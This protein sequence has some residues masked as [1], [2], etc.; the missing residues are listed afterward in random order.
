MPVAPAPMHRLVALQRAD[1]S[2]DL[3]DAFAAAI[4]V[5]LLKLEEGLAGTIGS[6][7]EVRRAWATAIALVWLGQHAGHVQSEWQLLGAKSE[8]YLAGVTATAPQGAPWLEAATA[9]LAEMRSRDP[10]GSPRI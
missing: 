5:S 1:G 3:T 2:W 7:A 4:G 9:F 6:R 8:K 10:A